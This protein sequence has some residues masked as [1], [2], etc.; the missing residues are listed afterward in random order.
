MASASSP[1]G[2]Q[3]RL[4]AILR[5]FKV[6]GIPYLRCQGRLRT[7][8]A[9][10]MRRI[11]QNKPPKSGKFFE[12]FDARR[13][14]AKASGAK[15]LVHLSHFVRSRQLECYQLVHCK[16]AMSKSSG[17]LPERRPSSG[18]VDLPASTKPPRYCKKGASGV[19]L[20]AR[21]LEIRFSGVQL[22][23]RTFRGCFAGMKKD[24]RWGVL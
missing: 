5:N 24:A 16:Q 4:A 1:H 21:F 14:G 11:A 7:H 9:Q 2:E 18:E 17:N 22:S 8:P 10:A 3:E 13:P 20:Q 15:S 19:G 23:G 6:Q 12:G